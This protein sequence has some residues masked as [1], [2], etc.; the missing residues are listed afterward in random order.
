MSNKYVR[1][2][3][4]Y[5][6]VTDGTHDS[7][8]TQNEG[9]PLVTSKHIKGGVLSLENANL[10]SQEDYDKINQRSKVNQWDV[11]ISMIG[12]YCGYTYIERNT[13]I[14]YAIK[15]VG[16]F[17]TRTEFEAKWLSYYLASSLGQ[18]HLKQSKLGSSQ[19]YLS[20]GS[21]RNLKIL[22]PDFNIK[23]KIILTLSALDDKID[24]NNKINAELEAMAKTIYDYWFVQ[25]DFPD[26][27]GRP[28]RSSGGKMVYNKT[29]KREIPEGWEVSVFNDWLQ[30]TKTGDWGKES[31]EGN[32]TERVYCVRGADI[33]GLN[34]K[35]EV[36]APQRYILQNNIHKKLEP[37]DFV[38]EISGGSPT[39]S[40]ARIAMITKEVLERFDTDVICS[41]FCKAVTLA[42]E[43]YAY[44]FQQEWQRLYDSK[45]FFGYEGKTSG[46]KNFLFDSFMASY[47]V[48]KPLKDITLQYH[49][50]AKEIEKKRQANLKQSQ[51]LASLRDWLL[52]MLMNGQVGFEGGKPLKRD[53]K[54]YTYSENEFFE[55][56]KIEKDQ[57]LDSKYLRLLVSS[58]LYNFLYLKNKEKEMGKLYYKGTDNNQ[59]LYTVLFDYMHF[60]STQEYDII[61]SLP[62]NIVIQ[63]FEE[64]VDALLFEVYYSS[65]FKN[66]HILIAEYTKQILR[67]IDRL[68][69]E[70]KIETIKEIYSLLQEKSNPLRNQI[71]LMK[72]ELS[73]LLLPILSTY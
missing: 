18:Y 8:K 44:N 63:L 31:E 27:N 46:I 45:V 22:N 67:S 41:N 38:I 11:I 29:L 7:P 69:I 13:D 30:N 51:E 20:L 59:F 26:T 3:D 16:L 68:E 37:N 12:E 39:Q 52:P 58:K 49:S 72:I 28:Y 57:T 4:L 71:K 62:N 47:H 34:G 1:A 21:L 54:I 55:K 9:Y 25:F 60:L 2:I 40:T 24:L 5:D 33:N 53:S 42:D 65:K 14:N 36:N 61:N 66:K 50:L 70:K 64:I 56:V 6:T 19:P 17:K 73:D 43:S 32:H 15:N 10:I 23:K 48:V 35:G